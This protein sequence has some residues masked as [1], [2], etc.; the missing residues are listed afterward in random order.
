MANK[1]FRAE[2]DG[3][4][5][6]QVPADRYWGA[7]TQRSLE[8][9]PIGEG[10]MPKAVIHAFGTIKLAAARV[11]VAQKTLDPK[12]GGAIE[13]AAAEVMA[14]RLD[15]HFPL[16]VWQTGSGTQTNMN[17]NEV[18][19]NRANEL[20]GAP[21]GAK[22]PV[23]PNDHV[24]RSQ[25][26]NDTF[27]SAMNIAAAR[28]ITGRLIPALEG[29]QR[30]LARKAK[31]WDGIVKIG[32]THLQ[33]AT[34]L[35]LGQ[36]FSGYAAQTA[37]GLE[38][39][40]RTLPDLMELAQGGTAVGTG[41][42]S[43]EGFDKKIA[44]EIA[45][46]TGLPFKPAAN[47]FEAMAAHDALVEAS[48]AINTI[49]VSLAKIANDIRLLGSG[50]RTGFA[51]LKL[52]ENEPGSSIMPGK[53]NP[54]QAEALTMVCARVFGNHVTITY[55]GASGHLE[56]NVFKPVMIY[57]LLDSIEHLADAVK[58]FTERCIK[59]I[60]PDRKRIRELLDKSLMLVTALAPEIGYDQ[61]AEVAKNALKKGITLLQSALELGAISEKRFRE[62]VRP[63]K[64]THPSK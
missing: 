45:K 50:P 63:E 38:R 56:L 25:S 57:S 20:L 16:V 52:P 29:L 53:V 19:A 9:F 39:V 1:A 31:A 33:D 62:I 18:I 46:L 54:T 48:G 58:S 15:D 44:A 10:T 24:N 5:T 32:R 35:T 36:E 34:P 7:L 4:G 22:S 47:K 51:E 12:L 28:A 13:K 3:F 26:S 27:P 23:H 55:A 8:N 37:K 49:A 30:E 11:N 2:K 21:L 59:G 61:A 42:N 40:K 60:E 41:L 17:A 14:G 43:K 64:M 6:I